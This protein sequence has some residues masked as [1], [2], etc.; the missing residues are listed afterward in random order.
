M[1]GEKLFRTIVP[2]AERAIHAGA[3]RVEARNS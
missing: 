3:F 1:L 2:E